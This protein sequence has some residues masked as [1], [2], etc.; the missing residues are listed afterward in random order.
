MN[1]L[2]KTTLF[3]NMALMTSLEKQNRSSL[4]RSIA[5]IEEEKKIPYSNEVMARLN[6]NWANQYFDYIKKS[7]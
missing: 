5:S 2:L 7:H 4:G 1:T 6:V 3:S